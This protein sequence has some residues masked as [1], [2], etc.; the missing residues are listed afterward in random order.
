MALSMTRLF[1]EPEEQVKDLTEPLDDGARK[2]L[3]ET[4]RLLYSA[5]AA[6]RTRKWEVVGTLAN[7]LLHHSGLIDEAPTELLDRLVLIVEGDDFSTWLLGL[8]DEITARLSAEHPA[9]PGQASTKA[10]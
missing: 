3:D 8:V 2:D 1:E 4:R 9:I 6:S 7:A 10:Q 5:M